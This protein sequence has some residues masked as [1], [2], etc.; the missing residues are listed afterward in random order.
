MKKLMLVLLFFIFSS[1]LFAGRQTNLGMIK[2]LLTLNKIKVEKG[3]AENMFLLRGTVSTVDRSRNLVV[4][5]NPAIVIPGVN[6]IP[7]DSGDQPYRVVFNG[8]EN[9]Y[10]DNLLPSQLFKDMFFTESVR[11]FNG[12]FKC[13]PGFCMKKSDGARF[14]PLRYDKLKKYSLESGKIYTVIFKTVNGEPEPVL[15]KNE[16]ELLFAKLKYLKTYDY[17][18]FEKLY[19]RYE[20]Q[21][22]NYLKTS[23]KPKF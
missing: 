8:N 13:I 15:I 14:I 17:A 18:N 20:H 1:T 6:F 11:L 5:K 3:D 4:F 22:K 21:I 12:G 9:R 16:M 10:R 23:G 2:E 7:M 19:K